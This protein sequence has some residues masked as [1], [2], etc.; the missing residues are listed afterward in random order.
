MMRM[1]WLVALLAAGRV[2]ALAV[3]NP[4]AT[5]Q[6]KSGIGNT[7]A[8][9]NAEL[10]AKKEASIVGRDSG[11]VG[12]LRTA[13]LS[14][15]RDKGGTLARLIEREGCVG[16]KGAL[17]PETAARLKRFVD[18]ELERSKEAVT[19]GAE[20]FEGRF[21]GVNCRGA[22]TFGSRADLYLPFDGVVRRAMA[23]LC[24]S[25]APLLDA[26]VGPDAAIHE[27]SS[28]VAD[29]GSPRQCV[30]A[31]TIV[32]PCPQYPDAV[33]APLY[34]LFVALQ[35]VEDGMGHTLF[36]PET[37]SDHTLWNVRRSDQERYVATRRAA[38]SSLKTGDVALFDSRCLHAGLGNDSAKRRTLFYCTLSRQAEWP[39]PGGLH[40]SNSLRAQ[41]RRR[42]TLRDLP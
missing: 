5:N 12:A 29:P 8:N 23:E 1:R 14:V 32:L 17:S 33:M 35:D 34:T 11:G 26:L 15:V 41:D 18:E 21:G 10:L 6:Q 22:G 30:H 42:W 28:L 16:L 25:L 20:P 37:H 40:G 39:L 9:L 13:P 31:D 4:G 19:A 3:A 2:G 36:L 38:Q 27:I 24:E 7:L